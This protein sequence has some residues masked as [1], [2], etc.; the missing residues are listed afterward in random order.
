[1]SVRPWVADPAA[2][3]VSTYG[4]MYTLKPRLNELSLKVKLK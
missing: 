1:M 3:R 2:F 4:Q